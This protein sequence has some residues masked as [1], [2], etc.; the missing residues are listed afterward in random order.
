[1]SAIL[2][3]LVVKEQLVPIILLLNR[4][5]AAK[6]AGN[7][8]GRQWSWAVVDRILHDEAYIGT[9]Y[10]NRYNCVTVEEMHGRKRPSVKCTLRPREKA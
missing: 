4:R 1:M 3:T 10:H 9:F 5:E 2:R 8:G 6:R 7:G